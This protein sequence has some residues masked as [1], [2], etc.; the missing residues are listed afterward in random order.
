MQREIDRG[1]LTVEQAESD[2]RRSVLLQ[3]I[4]ASDNVY[5]DFFFGDAK[6]D[7][8]Y[9][10]CSDGFRHLISADEIFQYLGPHAALSQEQMKA[11][12]DYLIR[13]NKERGERDNITVLA[14]RTY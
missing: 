14:V 2:P 6:K 12:S 8:V 3:C 1:N 9:M 11:Y 7:A 10:L 13:T 4:G 5:P